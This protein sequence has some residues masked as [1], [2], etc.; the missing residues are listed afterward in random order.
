MMIFGLGGI[1]EDLALPG[2]GSNNYGVYSNAWYGV[3]R[4]VEHLGF[5]L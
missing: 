2:S 3:E 5:G 4:G 1:V